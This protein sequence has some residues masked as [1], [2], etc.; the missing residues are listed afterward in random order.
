MDAI[1][2]AIRKS[3]F[4]GQQLQ[5]RWR[6]EDPRRRTQGARH[7]ACDRELCRTG[8]SECRI[9]GGRWWTPAAN[10]AD[11]SRYVKPEAL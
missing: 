10:Q 7:Q 9:R 3:L 2:S 6:S 1:E 11:G 4:P 5:R 8:S